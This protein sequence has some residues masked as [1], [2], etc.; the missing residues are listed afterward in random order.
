[1][2]RRTSITRNART[3][4]AHLRPSPSARP[5]IGRAPL[6]TRS[7]HTAKPLLPR[8]CIR[9]SV[10]ALTGRAAFSLVACALATRDS[11]SGRDLWTR[12]AGSRS[13]S[14]EADAVVLKPS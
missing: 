10:V 9:R 3:P 5:S 6:R 14:Q 13:P 1:M 4:R 12:P 7:I 8:L 2:A 11:A